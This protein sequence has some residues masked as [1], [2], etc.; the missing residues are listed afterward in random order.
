MTTALVI[1]AL[2]LTAAAAADEAP[3]TTSDTLPPSEA[4]TDAPA[5]DEPVPEYRLGA[6]DTITIKVYGE[7]DL[8]RDASITAACKIEVP[9]I[10]GVEVCGKT[11]DQVGETIRRRLADGFLR[12]PNVF[13]GV[14]TYGSQKV[15]VKGNVKKPGVYVLTGP[16]T[17]SAAVTLAGG[18]ESPNVI[19]VR[20]VSDDGTVEHSLDQMS[21]TSPVWVEPGDVVELLPPVTVQVF[22][23]VEESG[24]VAYEPGMTVTQALGLAGGATELAGLGRAYIRRADGSQERVNIRRIQLGKDED[25][26]LQPDDQLV[27]RRSIF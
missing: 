3:S 23:Q 8:S 4:D 25:V 22:G 26:V 17:L 7:D 12:E 27:I 2:S 10:G 6:G 24:P 14:S 9:L 15:E 19:R 5:Q 16:T 11:T 21:S 20:L 18:P 13:V 1:L